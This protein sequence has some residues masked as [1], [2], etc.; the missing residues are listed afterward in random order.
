M[1]FQASTKQNVTHIAALVTVTYLILV[2]RKFI[3]RSRHVEKPKTTKRKG[4][5]E[6]TEM[7]ETKRLKQAKRPKWPKRAKL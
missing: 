3:C 6:T 4:R 1:A 7:S 5:N 2:T